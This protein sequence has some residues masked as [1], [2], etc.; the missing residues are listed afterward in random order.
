MESERR[1][2]DQDLNQ[3]GMSSQISAPNVAQIWDAPLGQAGRRGM[4]PVRVEVPRQGQRLR[5]S[6]R[7]VSP[8]EASA[9]RFLSAP[10]GWRLPK[11][12]RWLTFLL[13]F[14]TTLSLGL[15]LV[16]RAPLQ[17]SILTGILLILTGLLSAAHRPTFLLALLL[18]ALGLTLVHWFRSRE[19]EAGEGF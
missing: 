4:L 5:F 17:W 3:L 19:K 12:S 1:D 16:F 13:T 8:G 14:A 2:G 6:R 7:L 18:A 10:Q 15:C 9:I 11:L